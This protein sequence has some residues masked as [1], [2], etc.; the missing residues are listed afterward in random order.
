VTVQPKRRLI[1]FG[2]PRGPR[3]ALA[4]QTQLSGRTPVAAFSRYADAERTVDLLAHTQFPVHRL[5]VVG[6]GLKLVGDGG[7]R[8]TATRL[9]A[10]GVCG[11]LWLGA[12]MAL[13]SAVVDRPTVGELVVRLSWGLPLGAVFGTALGL[14]GYAILGTPQDFASHGHLVPTRHELHVDTEIA[15]SAWRLLVK[16]H[17]AGMMLVDQVPAEVVAQPTELVLIESFEAAE[18]LPQPPGRTEPAQATRLP[19]FKMPASAV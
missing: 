13:F 15:T 14:T 7:G 1:R 9:S 3:P 2:A 4:D 17:P 5:T 11:G 8:I 16:L 18:P 6:S 10:L 19:R 12:L